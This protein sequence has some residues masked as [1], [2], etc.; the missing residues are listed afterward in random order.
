MSFALLA[1]SASAYHENFETL[2]QFEQFVDAYPSALI[3]L[4]S[5]C[6][7]DA[8]CAALRQLKDRTRVPTALALGPL[9]REVLGDLDVSAWNVTFDE[10]SLVNE[11]VLFPSWDGA[12]VRYDGE[13]RTASAILGWAWRE[14]YPEVQPLTRE[15]HAAV[16]QQGQRAV[17]WVFADRTAVTEVALAA[18]QACVQQHPERLVAVYTHGG[19]DAGRMLQQTVGLAGDSPLPTLAIQD[20]AGTGLSFT[21]PEGGGPP[22]PAA[23]ATFCAEFASG[24]LAAARPG[25][26]DEAAAAPRQANATLKDET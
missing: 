24:A 19:G 22:E 7:D 9:A 14:L 26:D 8:A 17:L 21:F 4:F 25:D 18:A 11:V 12:A 1:L 3:G 23:V 5:N 16:V 20:V 15:S 6:D 13:S 2:E 10:D